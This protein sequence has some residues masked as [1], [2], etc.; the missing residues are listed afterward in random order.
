MLNFA[1]LAL[2]ITT[3]VI[4]SK[5]PGNVQESDLMD[6][7]IEPLDGRLTFTDEGRYR[8]AKPIGKVGIN[9]DTIADHDSYLKARS[10]IAEDFGQRLLEHLN[11]LPYNLEIEYLTARH[12]PNRECRIK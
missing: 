7:N 9:T 6:N 4:L 1:W 8:L 5:E 2:S 12:L 11:K 3:F 10:L